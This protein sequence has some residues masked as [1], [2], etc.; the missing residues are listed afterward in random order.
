MPSQGF[1]SRKLLIV[2]WLIALNYIVVTNFSNM[3][4]VF[5]LGLWWV[6]LGLIAHMTHA[7]R[8]PANFGLARTRR[9]WS[10]EELRSPRDPHRPLGDILE[11]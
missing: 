8:A 4:V 3:R 5:G 10:G 11:N 1:L 6:T 2:L 9:A 7:H